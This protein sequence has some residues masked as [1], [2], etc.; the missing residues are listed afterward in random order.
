MRGDK[1]GESQ[2]LTA[3]PLPPCHLPLPS[4]PYLPRPLPAQSGIILIATPA[5]LV[6]LQTLVAGEKALTAPAAGLGM[7][8]EGGSKVGRVSARSVVPLLYPTPRRP[9]PTRTCHPSHGSRHGGSGPGKQRTESMCEWT[10]TRRTGWSWPGSRHRLGAW[11]WGG[12]AQG[13]STVDPS[14]PLWAP[15][16]SPAYWLQSGGHS[17]GLFRASRPRPRRLHAASPLRLVL[18]CHSQKGSWWVGGGNAPQ[19]S[20]CCARGKS[21]PPLQAHL[22]TQVHAPD[23]L[24]RFMSSLGSTCPV[25]TCFSG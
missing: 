18:W 10:G 23:C 19:L 17:S 24:L 14:T 15:W 5:A 20:F 21:M 2:T 4:V 6:A 3:S 8:T 25:F 13:H 9:Q 1:L 22:S 11:G 16:P 7:H 12:C